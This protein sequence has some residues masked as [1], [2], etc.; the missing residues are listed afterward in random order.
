MNNTNDNDTGRTLIKELA[1]M[2]VVVLVEIGYYSLIRDSI[3]RLKPI[4]D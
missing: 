2:V 4:T 3:R 1:S